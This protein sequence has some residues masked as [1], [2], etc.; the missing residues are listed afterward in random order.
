MSRNIEWKGQL[1]NWTAAQQVA[2]RLATRG[3]EQQ[4]QRD[5]YFATAN[6]RLKLREIQTA[7]EQRAELIWYQ[8]SNQEQTKASDYELLKMLE[9]E[10]WQRTLSQ[11]QGVIVIV[12]KERTIYCIKT[13][14][15]I[16]IA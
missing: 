8:R 13:C 14:A 15:S 2:A 6:G 5:T 3:P 11:A 16:W 10:R 12:E 7:H 4:H 9:P 1:A